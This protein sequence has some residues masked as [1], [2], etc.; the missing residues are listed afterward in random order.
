MTF[1]LYFGLIRFIAGLDDKPKLNRQPEVE[2]VE[3]E[4]E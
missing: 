2:L 3:E 4:E 1:I